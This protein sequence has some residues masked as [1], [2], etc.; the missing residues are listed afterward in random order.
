MLDGHSAFP[1]QPGPYD[2]TIFCVRLPINPSFPDEPVQ[3]T[4]NNSL[5]FGQGISKTGLGQTITLSEY[6]KHAQFFMRNFIPGLF[7]LADNSFAKSVHQVV[8]Y[9]SQ[10]FLKSAGHDSILH[11]QK[12]NAFY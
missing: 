6:Y 1:G 9:I 11:A 10:A 8:D 3:Q 7:A 5:V 2:T 12:D 4:C